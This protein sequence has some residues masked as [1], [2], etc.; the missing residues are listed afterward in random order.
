VQSD[1]EVA[2]DVQSQ[3]HEMQEVVFPLANSE[4]V[5]ANVKSAQIFTPEKQVVEYIKIQPT[6]EVVIIETKELE[7]IKL[8]IHP[9]LEQDLAKTPIGL[10]QTE[11]Q[12][13]EPRDKKLDEKTQLDL[14]IKPFFKDDML[15][16][17]TTPEMQMQDKQ[18]ILTGVESHQIF[19]NSKLVIEKP[20]ER[21]TSSPSEQVLVAIKRGVQ[22]RDSR[23]SLDLH[24]A[25]LGRV[26]VQIELRS[27]I[28]HSVKLYAEQRDT[29]N[30]LI[31]DSNILQ[32]SLSEVVK[33]E[34]ASLS[35]NLKD[36]NQDGSH[37][38]KMLPS[39]MFIDE[40]K[41]SKIGNYVIAQ[42]N[43]YNPESSSNL[44][45]RV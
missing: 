4:Q 38:E 2:T 23:I 27:G 29:L 14:A 35:F 6:Q 34:D 42:P 28:V 12:L 22:S 44:D 33:G 24:P 5:Q 25:E 11:V 37:K 9:K 40:D 7:L 16:E 19:A 20:S 1:S 39:M 30:I 18:S 15:E 41:V 13:I 10:D 8:A 43:S 3:P 17:N 32:R 31:K 21:Q 36:G 26:E 45:I